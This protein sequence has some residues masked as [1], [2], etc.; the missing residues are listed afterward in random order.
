VKKVLM[1]TTHFAPD[2]VGITMMC[3]TYVP[4]LR[5]I[6]HIGQYYDGYIILGGAQMSFERENALKDS[7]RANFV[8]VGEGEE[9]LVELIGHL[10]TR[11]DLADV[12]GLIY[13]DNGEIKINPPRKLITDLN[14]L[15]FPDYGL[16]GLKRFP[17]WY[18][19]RISTS[20][21]CPFRCVFCNP[22]NMQAKWRSRDFGLAIEELKFAKEQFGIGRFDICEPVFNLT[23]EGV[24]EFCE[25]LMREKIN[26]PWTCN[27]GLR[28][29][30]ITDEMIKAMKRAGFYDVKI[31]VETLAPG[32]FPN[33]NKGE[34]IEDIVRAVEIVKRNG[35]RI[36][37]SFIV[38]L[39]GS[40]Y[41]TD[42]E[43]FRRAQKLGFDAMAWS[44]LIP[45]PGTLAYYW[46][47]EHGTMYY[48]YKH[49]HQYAGQVV[50][51]E[52]LRVAFETP[53]YP[54]ADRIRMMEKISWTLKQSG[55]GE[56]K[57]SVLQ[58]AWKTAYNLARYDPWNVRGNLSYIG[59]GVISKFRRRR[60]PKEILFLQFTDLQ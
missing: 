43:S 24:I 4:A 5:L 34:T 3:T 1:I 47:F 40:S 29:D 22:H 6:E 10:E 11:K 50:G 19:Y 45:Y 52:R 42:M 39:P 9:T 60:Q 32:V 59:R 44:F 51:D 14:K 12:A 41:L 49:A 28:A 33:V 37:G 54:L 17:P 38:G 21:G 27:S 36:K 2:I 46:V 58:K 15:P 16:F 13:R 30:R 18:T 23:S 7:L 8:I 31:G 57:L 55:I 53:E 35:L 25:I 20:R 26:M 48:D 56:Q